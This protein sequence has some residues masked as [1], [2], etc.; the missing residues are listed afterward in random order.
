[1]PSSP[2]TLSTGEI[3]TFKPF[4]THAADAAVSDFLDETTTLGIDEA[5]LKKTR[6]VTLRDWN[7]ACGRA[8]PLLIATIT[9]GTD[10]LACS[11]SWLAEL[12]ADDY[13]RLLDQVDALYTDLRDRREREK[14]S[15]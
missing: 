2:V 14:K 5:G 4:L 8:L 3:V 15:H 7:R 9:K 10:A 12:P 13:Q 11:E 6:K 1:M